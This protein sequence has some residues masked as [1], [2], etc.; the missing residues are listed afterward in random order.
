M[1][2]DHPDDM[3]LAFLYGTIL[4]DGRDAFEDRPTRNICV[5]AE[6]EVN[7]SPTGIDVSARIAVRHAKGLI[8]IGPRHGRS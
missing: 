3:D 7:R 6:R 4:M 5:F 2:L 8:G 1:P